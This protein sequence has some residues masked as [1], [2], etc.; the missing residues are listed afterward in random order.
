MLIGILLNFQKEQVEVT[1]VGDERRQ[2][3][4]T[5]TWPQVTGKNAIEF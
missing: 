2:L 1:R 3:L 4:T 5:W